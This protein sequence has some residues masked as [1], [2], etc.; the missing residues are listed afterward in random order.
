[1][2]RDIW[3]NPVTVTPQ[4]RDFQTTGLGTPL[5]INQTDNSIYY[6]GPANAI[7]LIPTS[8][9][10]VGPAGPTGPIGPTGA[11]G[12]SAPAP[13]FNA[14]AG[15][16]I[17]SPVV[18]VTSSG[19]SANGI[20]VAR[21]VYD[22]LVDAT[23]V[24]ANPRTAF[25]AADG[26]GFKLDPA[27]RL[28]IEMFGVVAGGTMAANGA[29]N[30][31]GFLAANAFAP[32]GT[33]Y[34]PTIHL[35]G[36]YFTA[37][38]VN[39]HFNVNYNG[40]GTGGNTGSMAARSPT[41]I[42][43]PV[44]T[45][46]WVNHNSNTS[47]AGGAQAVGNTA[48]ATSIYE[49]ILFEQ[50]TQGTTATAYGFWMRGACTLRQ[51]GAFNI[52]GH[53]IF[54]NATA[55]SGGGTEGNDNGWVVDNC[56]AHTVRKDALHIEGNDSNA[57]YSLNFV[58]AGNTIGGCGIY[59]G[60]GLGNVH[61]APQIT[62]YGNTGVTQGGNQYVLL[63]PADGI[64]HS[65]STTPG[66]DNSIWYFVRAGAANA[67]FP[68]Y[69]GG[70]TYY[71]TAPIMCVGSSN[72][73]TIV[74]GYEEVG[75]AGYC[76][77]SAAG[78]A[79]GGGFMWTTYSKKFD[80]NP[81]INGSVIANGDNKTVEATNSGGWR[82][83]LAPATGAND[84]MYINAL[85]AAATVYG[86]ITYRGTYHIFGA[87]A[88]ALEVVRI[89]STGLNLAAGAAYSV[90][91]SA[92]PSTQFSSS[93]AGWVPASGGGTANFMRADGTWAS[94]GGSAFTY[95]TVNKTAGYTETTTTGCIVIEANSA[96]GFT[97]TL[98]TAVGNLAQFVIKK[99][100]VAGQITVATTAAQTIDGGATAVLNNAGESIT[101]ISNGAQW[102]IM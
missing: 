89:T 33:Y 87:G 45:T 40:R 92:L 21:Y 61:V 29:S 84:A 48:A 7:T 95:S 31:I 58:T 98:P 83:Q 101:I 76:H 70:T 55:A 91:G 16:T 53:G 71:P 102:D 56:F 1:M 22:A 64:N 5:V 2:P 68:A 27:Q 42:I 23:Y 12:S 37:Q 54:I 52:A 3:I 30:Y 6:L 62:G 99:M 96:A 10:A 66:T 18:V 93:L 77:L 72:R 63:I 80:A 85:N 38:T 86:N 19:Y 50:E 73:T 20:G 59:D 94:V 81:E 60:S 57:G 97:I 36:R 65:A 78:V 69:V 15:S 74:G 4:L 51:C 8:G 39:C 82:V 9:G 79:L 41:S 32:P 100:L 28:A 88:S 24:T 75:G 67:Q 47:D 25:L 26:R 11:T 44:N 14:A 43:S 90:N 46:T 13:L 17:T 35:N 34:A 49:G